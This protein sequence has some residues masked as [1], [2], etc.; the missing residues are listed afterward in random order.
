MANYAI[1]CRTASLVLDNASMSYQ[2][3]Y[4]ML[5]E[6]FKEFEDC[7]DVESGCF[8]NKPEVKQSFSKGTLAKNRM[9]LDQE[10]IA[11]LGMSETAVV[12]THLDDY[13]IYTVDDLCDYFDDPRHWN[14]MILSY[15][16]IT[17][18]E[19]NQKRL[20]AV[21]DIYLDANYDCGVGARELLMRF[22]SDCIPSGSNY[23]KRLASWLDHY[24]IHTLAQLKYETYTKDGFPNG[25]NGVISLNTVENIVKKVKETY[26][27][28]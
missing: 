7:K 8:L 17:Y 9:N 5:K 21:H 14:T 20:D 2:E 26:T 15:S 3:K 4:N 10:L 24:D 1:L 28:D 22:C 27:N 16:F 23:Q 25:G 19:L 18:P 6:L 12:K 13:H 11:R